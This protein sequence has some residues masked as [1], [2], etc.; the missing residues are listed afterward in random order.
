[1]IDRKRKLALAALGM[2]V[3]L[4]LCLMAFW[5]TNIQKQETR[6]APNSISIDKPKTENGKKSHA[7]SVLKPEQVCEQV[8]PKALATY[9]TDGPDRSTKLQQYF[10]KDAKGLDMP[11]SDIQS[12]PAPIFTGYLAFGR[13]NDTAICNVWTGLESPWCLVFSYQRSN[14]WKIALVEGPSQG[15][16]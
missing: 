10:I 3:V 5:P 7:A 2:F 14:G 15:F 16:R 4:G 12:Q 9:V 11:V 8:A 6:P 1:M 13:D